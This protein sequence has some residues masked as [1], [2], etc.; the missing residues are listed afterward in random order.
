MQNSID[1]K[2]AN[3]HN[4]KNVSVSIPRGKIV[5]FTGRSGSGK[6]S[7]AFDTI[8]AE[9]YRKYMESL[10]ADA[11]GLLRQMDKPDVESISGLSPVIA[12]EQS[13]S[14]GSNPRSTLATLTEIADYARIIWSI[15]TD[16]RCPKCGGRIARGSVDAGCDRI[17]SLP[18]TARVYI[19]SPVDEAK[20]AAIRERV[21]SLRQRA[22]TRVLINGKMLELDSPDDETR[23]FKTLPAGKT[24]KL[25]LVIDRFPMSGVSRGRVADSLELALKE[26]SDKAEA[27]VMD[28][29]KESRIRVSA[30]L[31][32]LDCGE[33]FGPLTPQSFSFNHPTGACPSCGGLGRLMLTSPELAV[34]DTSKSIRAGAIR[35]WRF[36]GRNLIITHNKILRQLAE[37]VPF[38]LT[39]PWR[40]LDESVR[41]L[42]LFGD[43]KRIFSL[44]MGRGRCKTAEI[45]F[46]GV[47]SMCDHL[48][49]I[50]TSDTLRARLASFQTSVPCP[51]CGGGGGLGGVREEVE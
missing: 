22:W 27:L 38:S 49:R 19:L 37:Q 3:V 17:M 45:P 26:G 41:R 29:G 11:R 7:L 39:T 51:D 31:A 12:I 25:E 48:C 9:G 16:Q 21:K 5:A 2:G 1:V 40:D 44:K 15:S 34:P 20:P 13:K 14:L 33:T 32:C 23:L 30:A 4:L 8:Y 47:L 35:P 46:E 43:K 50:T 42:I 18:Q 36:G 24:A 28:G 6:S 10:S